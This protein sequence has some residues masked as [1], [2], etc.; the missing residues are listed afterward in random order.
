MSHSGELEGEKDPLEKAAVAGLSGKWRPL[1]DMRNAFGFFTIMPLSRAG[2]IGEIG[3]ASYLLPFVA[4]FL[5]ALEGAAGWGSSQVFGAPVAA[6][7]V[8]AAALLLT[9]F[10]HSDGLGDLGDA[11]MVHGDPARRIE[12]LKD[13]TMG[14]GAAGT[15]FLTYLISWAAIAGIITLRPGFQLVLLI[16]AAELSAR[17][18]LLFVGSLGR[19]SHQGSGS[20]FAH[21]MKGWRGMTGILFTLVILASMALFVPYQAVLFSVGAALAAGILLLLISGR[22]FGGIGGDVLGASVELGRLV[23]LLGLLAGLTL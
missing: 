18:C 16:M 22:F 14:T 15:L 3:A 19:P 20:S 1:R 5:G 17:L 23:A 8:L 11:L 9:G 13:R 12:V 6:A 7:L 21:V 2:T 10:H 4:A